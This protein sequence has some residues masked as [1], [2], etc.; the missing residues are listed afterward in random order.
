MNRKALSTISK[1]EGHLACSSIHKE[2]DLGSSTF[3]PRLLEEQSG[4][5]LHQTRTIPVMHDSIKL[6][7]QTSRSSIKGSH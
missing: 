3:H 6:E 5:S 7:D 2:A 1:Q 4:A